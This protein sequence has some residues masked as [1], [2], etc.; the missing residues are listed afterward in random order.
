MKAVWGSH[1]S[2]NEHLM[3]QTWTTRVCRYLWTIGHK[4][5]EARK[6]MLSL[7]YSWHVGI[8]WMDQASCNI[9]NELK[10]EDHIFNQKGDCHA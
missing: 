3:A 7:H 4:V 6:E 2:T 10:M 5:K 8:V 1:D 9:G